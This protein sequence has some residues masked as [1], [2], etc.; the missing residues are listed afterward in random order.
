MF[1]LSAKDGSVRRL[2]N[3]SPVS[4]EAAPKAERPN[5]RLDGPEAMRHHRRLLDHYVRELD[6]QSP[7][8]AEMA[9]DEDFYDN[10][11]WRDEDKATLKAR[12]QVPLVYN[13]ISTS[14]DWVLG[15]ERRGRSDYKILPRRKQ[16]SKPAERKSQLLKYLS[17][18]NNTTFHV[19]RAFADAVKVG[20][21][22]LED[23]IQDGDEEPIYSRYESWRNMLADS[24]A[25]EAD[26][27]DARYIFRTKWVDL[28]IASAMFPR[29]RGL[30]EHSIDNAD[31][32]AALS[33]YGDDAM[34][35]KEIEL[36][37]TGTGRRADDAT[38]GYFRERVRLIEAWFRVPVETEV[39]A[40]G[41]FAGE[42]YDRQSPGHRDEI[43]AGKAEI[44][45]RVMLRMHVA[46]FTATGMLYLG[47]SPYR[48]NRY[49][50]TPV[51]GYRRGKTGLPYGMIRRMR[52]IQEDVNKRASKALHILSTNK[53]IMD[54]GA[55]DDLDEFAE[56]IARPDGIIVR[57]PGKA[58]DINVDRDLSQWH[59]EM[60]SR[61]ISLLQ[62]SSGV[63]DELL[64]RRTN[65]NSGIAIQSRQDQ[66]QMATSGLFDNLR[67]AKQLS[68]EKQCSLIEQYMS[69]PK[70]FRITN[71]RGAPEYVEVNDGLPDNDITRSKAD[72]VISEADWRATVRQAQTDELFALMR[73]IAPVAPQVI[74][75]MLDLLVEAM[76]LP[77]RDELVR[78]IR[79]A[80]GQRDPDQDEPTAEDA[81]K[82]QAEAQAQQMT[83]AM[84]MAQLRAAMANAAKAEAQVKEI[85]AKIPGASVGA[86]KSA[87]EAAAMAIAQP[88]AVH[89]ADHILA[90]SGFTSRTDEQQSAAAAEAA[91]RQ[92]QQEAQ[93]A[94]NGQQ[95]V[96]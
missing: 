56:E 11:Q 54:E 68:G 44:R 70:A 62:S 51:W 65:A 91:M 87:L 94:P 33:I 19:S 86:Q 57:K 27:S 63:T 21:G 23:G 5:D 32:L 22:W 16:D 25:S 72:Y 14:I 84:A 40:G 52:D 39:V 61:S 4:A 85:L 83:Q 80:T 58:I 30:L 17:D 76:D 47:Q 88:Q 93:G 31:Q 64:G 6:R 89:V 37:R 75:I 12:G 3:E 78:R 60:M 41:Q 66:G 42:I 90:E 35:A 26:L 1:D 7:N 92:Q 81:A 29:R 59:L 34:D 95:P 50:F 82:A 36:N 38:G 77:N 18:C 9:R 15:S 28:D 74:I 46:I 10:E 43:G 55:V 49:P 69:E 8:R 13:V 79:Q 20:V 24:S 53:V 2:E 67:L 48:H 96:Y 71:M 45:K 73:Q